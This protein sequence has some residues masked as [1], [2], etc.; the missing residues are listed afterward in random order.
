MSQL[1]PSLQLLPSLN[2]VRNFKPYQVIR[3][4]QDQRLGIRSQRLGIPDGILNFD[5][6]VSFTKEQ[7][8]C[9]MKWRDRI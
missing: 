4:I 9:R 3:A 5:Q 6:T 8:I 1:T 2:Q 7:I